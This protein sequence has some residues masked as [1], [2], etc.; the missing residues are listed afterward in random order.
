MIH[1]KDIIAAH[2]TTIKLPIRYVL[3][4]TAAPFKINI[5][6]KSPV[7][8]TPVATWLPGRGIS[9]INFTFI[10][11]RDAGLIPTMEEFCEQAYSAWK[12]GNE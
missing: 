10:V 6:Y 7:A 12:E 1:D 4:T 5:Y 3:H 9:G 2:E 8:D 11:L